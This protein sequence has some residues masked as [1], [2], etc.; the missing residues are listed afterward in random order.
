M[1]TFCLFACL[2]S[3]AGPWPVGDQCVPMSCSIVVTFPHIL[4]FLHCEK[5]IPPIGVENIVTYTH[6]HC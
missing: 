3:A 1:T 5:E 4:T 6:S 2:Y